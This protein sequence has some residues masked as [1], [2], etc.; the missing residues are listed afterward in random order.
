[1]RS[2]SS[3][4]IVGLPAVPAGWGVEDLRE[5]KTLGKATVETDDCEFVTMTAKRSRPEITGP[6]RTLMGHGGVHG[7]MTPD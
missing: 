3:G 1:V 2:I 7:W 6:V 4:G 5:V